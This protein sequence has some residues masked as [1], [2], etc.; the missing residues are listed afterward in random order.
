MARTTI[1]IFL[2]YQP[3]GR[4]AQPFVCNKSSAHE[5]IQRLMSLVISGN[6]LSESCA[7]HSPGRIILMTPRCLTFQNQAINYEN[8]IGGSYCLH[9]MEPC[10]R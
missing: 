1:L 3:L 5:V 9:Q 7:I 10:F 8:R 2:T 6:V 4:I